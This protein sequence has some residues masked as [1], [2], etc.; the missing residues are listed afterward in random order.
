MPQE[1]RDAFQ[2]I[3]AIQN[4]IEA[5]RKAP[6]ELIVGSLLLTVTA[7]SYGW[8]G[9]DSDL[10]G[11]EALG[12]ILDGLGPVG[13]LA[14]VLLLIGLVVVGLAL[15][16]FRAWLHPGYIRLH[17]DLVGEGKGDFGVLFGSADAFWNMLWWK[18][19]A[20][21]LAALAMLLASLPGLLLSGL[22]YAL[23]GD[24]TLSWLPGALVGG[25][26][27][28]PVAIYV[29]L[30]LLLGERAVALDGMA[31]MQAL[32]HSWELARGSRLTLLAFVIVTGAFHMLGLLLCCV[33]IV[34][35]RAIVDVGLTESYLMAT[36][37]GWPERPPGEE[38]GTA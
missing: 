4:G 26:L 12:G 19:L 21:V 33:G 11:M 32:G 29:Y 3:R 27:V 9:S 38:S 2:P 16:A 15:W 14:V 13:V 31:P 18:L 25:L 5:M 36:R 8:G 34:V 10:E 24:E 1:M 17:R 35:T 22:G 23:G 6:G 20:T 30:G 7:G 37:D 28:V